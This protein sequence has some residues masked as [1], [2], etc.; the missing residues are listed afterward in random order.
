M[1]SIKASI[2][3]Y[4]PQKKQTVKYRA[5]TLEKCN[6]LNDT[7]FPYEKVCGMTIMK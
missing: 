1:L 6:T 5:R 2:I 4:P 3:I 7:V